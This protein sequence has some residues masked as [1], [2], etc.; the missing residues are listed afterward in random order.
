MFRTFSILVLTAT[1]LTACS[2]TQ[3]VSTTTPTLSPTAQPTQT[4]TSTPEATAIP[5]APEATPTETPILDEHDLK[6]AYTET[7]NETFMGVAI[8]AQLITDESLDPE[9]KKVT[10][11][12]KTYAEFIARTVFDVWWSKGDTPHKGNYTDTDFK[13]FMALWAK[14]QQTN[15]PNDWK[16][17]ELNNIW[18]NDLNDGNGYKQQPY[19]IWP[20]YSGTQAPEGVRGINNF[21][22]A[23]V[24]ANV[25]KDTTKFSN[26]VYDEGYGS[27]VDGENLYVYEGILNM[28]FS[29]DKYS[30]SSLMAGATSQWLIV[31]SGGGFSGYNN[32]GIDTTILNLLIANMKVS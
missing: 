16:Q 30:V 31:N 17:V 18:A 23:L 19:T 13:N 11:E 9:I 2:Q 6:P 14:A 27:N 26:N 4:A 22:I 8:N 25:M 21:A 29:P 12:P 32:W 5:K 1:L 15:D 3:P 20:M 24:K 10:V 28:G 7:V